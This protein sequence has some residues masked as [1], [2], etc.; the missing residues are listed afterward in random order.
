LKGNQ[1][2]VIVNESLWSQYTWHEV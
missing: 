1:D 2:T